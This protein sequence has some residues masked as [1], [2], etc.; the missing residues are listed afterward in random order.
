MLPWY[1]GYKIQPSSPCII[2]STST[3]Q[4]QKSVNSSLNY[5]SQRPSG[6]LK[7]Y[8]IHLL[9]FQT[10]CAASMNRSTSHS[11]PRY[12]TALRWWSSYPEPR[13]QLRG[14]YGQ[15]ALVS[16]LKDGVST[17]RPMRHSWW[18]GEG[19]NGKILMRLCARKS[20]FVQI[21]SLYWFEGT[22]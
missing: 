13:T 8:A 16:F 22:K 10:R 5:T 15:K 17:G 18:F 12:R 21:F 3:V 19:G 20:Q 6:S 11:A 7:T 14:S 1:L 9:I 4:R 2:F